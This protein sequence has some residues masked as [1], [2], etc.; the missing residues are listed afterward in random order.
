MLVPFDGSTATE[1][2][3]RAACRACLDDDVPLVVLCVVP[4]PA[5]RAAEETPPDLKAAVMHAL[6]RANEICGEEGVVA[7]FRETYAT[8]LA[9]EIVRIANRLRAVVVALPLENPPGDAQLAGPALQR[10]LCHA[11]CSV[12]LQ[13]IPAASPRTAHR[14]LLIVNGKDD[15][16]A[17]GHR[18]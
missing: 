14:S 5:G 2:V 16:A 9:D 7:T 17:T 15:H 18:A 4:I 1:R 10:V 8:D 3:L 13:P 12:V 11:G 6:V